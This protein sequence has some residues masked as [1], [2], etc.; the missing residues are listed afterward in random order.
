MAA[1]AAV[2]QTTTAV[3][4]TGVWAGDLPAYLVG[5][6]LS[7]TPSLL[8][9]L[10][11]QRATAGIVLGKPSAVPACPFNYPPHLAALG[12][13][14]PALT[15]DGVLTIWLAISAGLL[16]AVVVTWSRMF[17][18][19][20]PMAIA[21]LASPPVAISFLTGSILPIAA[22]GAVGA[23]VAVQRT[24]R[25]WTAIGAVGW[26]AVATKPHLAVVLALICLV[27]AT[28]R[29]ATTLLA[30][31]PVIFVAPTLLLGPRVWTSWFSFLGRFSRS[32]EGD[33]MCRVPRVAPNLE[34]VLTRAGW[35]PPI[36]LVW[37]GYVAT[38]V[39][40]A[41]WVTRSRP[42][43]ALA[44]MVGAALV[45]LT[46]PHANPQDLLLS[47]PLLAIPATRQGRGTVVW[48]AGVAVAL[49]LGKDNF[50]VAVQLGVAATIVM[51]FVRS[52][53]RRTLEAT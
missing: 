24:G 4:R 39:C 49:F 9:N 14:L 35:S 26:V 28:R 44:C 20:V 19:R 30:A 7:H 46:A 42:P 38:I 50:T 48:A 32:T 31:A 34:G 33:L 40:L 17:R 52:F 47:I 11:A 16:I 37:A 12:R 23:I 21:V 15:Y 1:L 27:L 22:A 2:L 10:N 43:L 36:G 3:I 18:H 13:T 53:R 6:R 41:V 5:W 8:Y 29:T 51:L 25:R 45:P